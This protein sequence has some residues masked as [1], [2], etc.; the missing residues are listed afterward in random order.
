MVEIYASVLLS[1]NRMPKS[2]VQTSFPTLFWL[3]WV[4]IFILILGLG[5]LSVSEREAVDVLGIVNL[6]NFQSIGF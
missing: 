1:L 2:S 4:S 6:V 5:Y 3:F